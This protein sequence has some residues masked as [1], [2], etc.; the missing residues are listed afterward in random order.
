MLV[1]GLVYCDVLLLCLLL[2]L[3]VISLTGFLEMTRNTS[4]HAF[5]WKV[6]KCCRGVKTQASKDGVGFLSWAV[7]TVKRFSEEH[8]PL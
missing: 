5:T 2:V 8:H 7:I 6:M 1:T 4:V 3:I